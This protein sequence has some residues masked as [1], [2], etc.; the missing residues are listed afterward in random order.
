MEFYFEK[1]D[2]WQNARTFVKEIYVLTADFPQDEKYGIVSQLRRAFLSISANIA[3]GMSRRTEKEKARFISISFG[4]AMEVIN[5]LIL[6]NDLNLI[7]EADYN[8]L[9]GKLEKITNQL[10]SLHNKLSS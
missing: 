4:S 10:N 3:E 1:M 9:R 8:V 2:V 5:F 6:A 7:E